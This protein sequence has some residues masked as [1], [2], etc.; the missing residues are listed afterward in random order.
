MSDERDDRPV[1]V[2]NPHITATDRNLEEYMRAKRARLGCQHRAINDPKLTAD[3]V[4]VLNQ[5]EPRK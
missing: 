1:A 3:I 5:M 2:I 4:F